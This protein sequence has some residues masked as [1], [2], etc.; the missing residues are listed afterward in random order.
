MTRT[1]DTDVVII[2]SG[3][4]GINARRE[5]ERAGKRWVVV[6]GGAYGTMCA[7]VG[8]MPSK[9][10]IAAGDR[11]HEILGSDVFGIH[12]DHAA[13]QVD[14][15]A[16]MQRVQRE[17]DRFV[18]FVLDANDRLPRTQNLQ[19]RARL[20]STT[21]VLIEDHTRV[22][23]RAIVIATGSAPTV[24][25]EL[26]ALGDRLLTNETVF[27]LPDL[28]SSLAVIGTGVIGLEL[29]QAMHRLGVRTTLFSRHGSFA[30]LTD[31]E[32]H[33]RARAHFCTELDV[34]LGSV[35]AAERA[36]GGARLRWLEADGPREGVFEYVLAA[37]GR[38]PEVAGLGLEL[39]GLALDARGVPLHDRATLQCGDAPIFLA[40]DVTGDLTVLHEAVDDGRIAGRNAARFPDVEPGARR[41]PMA[42]VFSDPNCAFVG[43]RF[44]ELDPDATA[45]G[46]VSY[47]N[48][49]RSRMAAKNTGLV[50]MYGARAD[51]RLIGAELFGP[52]MEH[53]AHLLAWSIQSGLTVDQMLAMP[54]YHP[55]FE[56]G[57]RTGLQD[58]Q[59][60]MSRG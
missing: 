29:G 1:L 47:D 20:V 8:C 15:R 27:E 4:A 18:G 7:R 30:G 19:G 38:H 21:S 24:P 3:T 52:R 59:R 50:R 46:E 11:R 31:P 48:Q 37:T 23:A 22:D 10:L 12:V 42:V 9:L 40:G 6:E 2:G 51:G 55:V 57:I 34:R 45:I 56:E 28:P 53:M 49:G 5:V 17:R 25:P 16:V 13:V 41:T 33:A 44:T 54:F 14:G 43:R 39:L 58:L 32:V 26:A 60:R 35:V 36:D